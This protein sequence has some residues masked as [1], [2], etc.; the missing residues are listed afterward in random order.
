MP[1]FADEPRIARRAAAIW[2]WLALADLGIVFA[3][4]TIL[5]LLFM[6]GLYFWVFLAWAAA[7]A[8]AALLSWRHTQRTS[9]RSISV[10]ALFHLGFAVAYPGV[11]LPWGGSF[12]G[13][14]P[15]ETAALLC[16]LGWLATAVAIAVLA[17]LV[18]RK[19][20]RELA[21]AGGSAPAGATRG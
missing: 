9:L 3:G 8:Y 1:P 20:R 12:G 5:L 4:E 21:P 11:P 2:F 16:R 19:I 13:G 7:A 10:L 6:I 14:M 17:L 15:T 18:R